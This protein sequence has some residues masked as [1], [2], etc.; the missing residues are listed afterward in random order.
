MSWQIPF[1]CVRQTQ[2]FL[3][4]RISRSSKV[5]LSFIVPFLGEIPM[6]PC[7]G[8]TLSE[9]D[10]HGYTAS[11]EQGAAEV[12]H[13]GSS[14]GFQGP[15]SRDSRGL[16]NYSPAPHTF[17]PPGRDSNRPTSGYRSG[18]EPAV[19]LLTSRPVGPCSWVDRAPELYLVQSRAP[20][21]SD[22]Q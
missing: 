1:S 22:S 10:T 12:Q 5:K 9:V 11:R 3:I 20:G 14:W 21:L 7:R 6:N 2:V 8:V 4:K 15:C 16:Q 19:Q 17:L 13:P 18:F